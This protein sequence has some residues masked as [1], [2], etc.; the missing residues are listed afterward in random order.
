M[1]ATRDEWSVTYKIK[2]SGSTPAHRT[3]VFAIAKAVA[4]PAEPLPIPSARDSLG[5][6]APNGDFVDCDAGIVDGLTAEEFRTKAKVI[7][8]VGKITYVDAFG[9]RRWTKFCYAAPSEARSDGEMDIHDSGNE[10]T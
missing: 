5:S 6:L 9:R 7:F 8:L 3:Y 10:S 4:W 1:D 2:N